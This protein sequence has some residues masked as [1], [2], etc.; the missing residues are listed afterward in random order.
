[1]NRQPAKVLEPAD[2]RRLLKHVQSTRY[3]IR[4]RAMVLLSF[5]AGLRAC[6]IAG[7]TWSMVLTSNG[8]PGPAIHVA[9]RIAKQ[10]HARCVPAHPDLGSVL[11]KLH[12]MQGKPRDGRRQLVPRHLQP[13]RLG[14][15]LL[16]FR[17][18]HLHHKIRTAAAPNRRLS[19]GRPGACRTPLPDNDRTLHCRQ[20][21]CAAQARQADL[22]GWTHFLK[23]QRNKP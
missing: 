1:M 6:E 15:L 10:G 4:N 11:K 19:S 23:Q 12:L 9:K 18:P 13:S 16:A 2:F 17:A 8:Q 22:S 14:W 21:G 20:P 5:K 7:L 3:P